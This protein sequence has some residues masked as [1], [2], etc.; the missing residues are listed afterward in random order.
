MK[1]EWLVKTLAL[2]I[3]V[4]FIGVVIAPCIS[5]VDKE[6]DKNN[7]LKDS[8]EIKITNDYEEIITFINGWAKINWI[9]RRGLFHGEVNLTQGDYSRT[10]IYLSG[11]R[12][13]ENGIEY[14]NVSVVDGFV[15]AYHFVGL[16]T[17]SLFLEPP[18]VVWGI[19]FGNIEWNG[20]I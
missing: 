2:S 6:K 16:N 20:V 4:L 5:A 18:P 17:P 8:N 10:L 15:Y 11:F 14:Y 1:K 12:S 13:S 19:T 7:K 9:E 3:I